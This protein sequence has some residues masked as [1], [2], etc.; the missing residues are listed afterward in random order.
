MDQ[1]QPPSPK[2]H[3]PHASCVGLLASPA[4]RAGGSALF[5]RAA[6]SFG[7]SHA[8]WGGGTSPPTGGYFTLEQLLRGDSFRHEAATPAADTVSGESRAAR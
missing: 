6:S 4:C 5:G 8:C 3:S 7:P 2:A 1:A